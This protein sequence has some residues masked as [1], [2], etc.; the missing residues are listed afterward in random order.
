MSLYISLIPS[1]QPVICNLWKCELWM[2][3]LLVHCTVKTGSKLSVKFCRC[4]LRMALRFACPDLMICSTIILQSLHT[5]IWLPF[6]RSTTFGL[7]TVSALFRNRSRD[8]EGRELHGLGCGL[9]F[10]LFLLF[11]TLEYSS[12]GVHILLGLSSTTGRLE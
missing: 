8:E 6:N 12:S 10:A 11:N 3:L 4:L 9:E 2:Q 7:V 5:S 1:T